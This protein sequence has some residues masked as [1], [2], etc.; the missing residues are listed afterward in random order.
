MKGQIKQIVFGLLFTVMA[1]AGL[2]IQTQ[3]PCPA[4]PTCAPVVQ[5]PV[6]APV[7]QVQ[8]PVSCPA[9]PVCAPAP[10]A[11]CGGEELDD[12]LESI[13]ENADSFRSHIPDYLSECVID[14]CAR[15][16]FLNQYVA[17]FEVATDQ[18][19]DNF[20]DGN[21]ISGDAQAVLNRAAYIDSFMSSN[22]VGGEAATEWSELRADL[23]KLA[24]CYNATVRWGD[25]AY[26]WNKP[27]GSLT[28]DYR[29][30]P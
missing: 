17:D 7:V 23:D 10:P 12:L 9:Q 19:E 4:Q 26:A 2:T 1:G 11:C 18:L 25:P 27:A 16:T 24:S 28:A 5:T 21:F 30:N 8:E 29:L 13:E 20:K 6:C 22:N 15:E 3:Q 14:K